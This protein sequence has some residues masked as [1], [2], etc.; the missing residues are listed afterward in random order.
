MNL[1]GAG[2]IAQQHGAF[3]ASA[4]SWVWFLVQ[5]NM[6]LE[7]QKYPRKDMVPEIG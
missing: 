1:W 4:K 6:N 5:K 3:Q 2:D 7:I